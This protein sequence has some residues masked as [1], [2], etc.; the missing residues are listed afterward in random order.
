MGDVEG[1]SWDT[2]KEH[3]QKA[4]QKV[5]KVEQ[6]EL[7]PRRDLSPGTAYIVMG[8]RND[9]V[10]AVLEM[11]GHVLNGTALRVTIHFKQ[12]AQD[13]K[14]IRAWY[15]QREENRAAAARDLDESR[16]QT[17]KARLRRKRLKKK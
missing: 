5:G 15:Q 11:N 14:R 9:A 16:R 6:V 12:S 2:K 3:L 4:F 8:S 7:H 1:V 10:Q 17:R 13:K